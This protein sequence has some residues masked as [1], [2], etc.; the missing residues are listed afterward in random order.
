MPG[1]TV[2]VAAELCHGE[3]R[4]A[5]RLAPLSPPLKALA[6]LLRASETLAIEAALHGSR[7]QAIESLVIHPACPS[8]QHA[9]HAVD[10]LIREVGLDLRE[11][12]SSH[13][14]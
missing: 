13:V 10:F 3:I 4:P 11:R 1:R 14:L 2:E 9:Q 8:L 7:S 6:S 5:F 12:D